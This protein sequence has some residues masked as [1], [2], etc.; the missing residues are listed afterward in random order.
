MAE[1]NEEK[2]SEQQKA[3]LLHL[4]LKKNAYLL[5]GAKMKAKRHDGEHDHSAAKKKER[6]E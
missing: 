4:N 5:P 1:K 6:A 2:S 3:P